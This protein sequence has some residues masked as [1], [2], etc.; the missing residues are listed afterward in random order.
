MKKKQ[1]RFGTVAIEKGFITAVDLLEAMKIQ[2]T[3]D[4]ELKNHRPI[5]AILLDEGAITGE[6]LNEVLR[7]MNIP[8]LEDEW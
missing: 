1:K 7:A 3:E 4:I 5:G 2:I 6:Q 8:V